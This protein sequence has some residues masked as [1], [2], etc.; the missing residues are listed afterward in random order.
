MRTG[1]WG[2]RSGPA[3]RS[4]PVR[5]PVDAFDRSTPVLLVK[6]GQYPLHHGCVA[7]VRSFGRVGVPVYAITE[8][9]YTPT[10]LSRY[11]RDRFVWPTTGT[12]DHQLLLD[13][14]VAVARRLAEPAVAVATD[15]E[16]AVL[17]AEASGELRDWLLLPR[18]PAGLPRRLASKRGLYELCQA[19][20]V[21]TPKAVF[22]TCADEVL[23]FAAQAKFPVVAKN[24][25]PWTRLRMPSV[26]GTTVIE[27]A[28]DL[29][30]LTATWPTKPNVMLQEYIPRNLAEDWIFHAYCD[31][32]SACP[33]AFSGF[34][35]RSWPPHAGVSTC[36][37]TVAN[38]TLVAQAVRFCAE[39]GFRGIVDLDWRLDRRDG[40]YKLVDFNPR[41][42]AQFQLFQTT[43]GIDVVRALHLDLTGRTIPDAEPVVGRRL[44]VEN[45]DLPASLAY[46]ALDRGPAPPAPVHIR[47]VLAWTAIDDPLPLAVMWVRM[48]WQLLMRSTSRRRLTGRRQLGVVG[49]GRGCRSWIGGRPWGRVHK[50]AWRGMRRG[51]TTV[52]GEGP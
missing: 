32:Q 10:A 34:K 38:D 6:I 27:S 13:G 22:P 9:R 3:G 17:L 41:L 28:E 26:A 7:A 43:A 14:L 11:L 31:D 19:H 23:S 20:G 8:D 49:A 1:I 15:D 48:L 16:A 40:Q 50:G 44:I 37:V 4:E 47:T 5:D 21:P 30:R 29:R 2:A 25:D 18:V 12:E 52:E 35:V 42:G 46:R 51:P 45:L 24:V 39:V 33:V 36:A